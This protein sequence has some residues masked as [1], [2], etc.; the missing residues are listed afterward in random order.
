VNVEIRSN[1]H[2]NNVCKPLNAKNNSASQPRKSDCRKNAWRES[3]SRDNA[4][5]LRGNA[6]Q[7]SLRRR[8]E[9]SD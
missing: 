6:R 7:S 2:W 8:S 4:K 9:S 5:Q 1:G 3:A